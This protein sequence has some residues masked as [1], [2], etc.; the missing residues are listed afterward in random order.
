MY[1]KKLYT[2]F[3]LTP[4]FRVTIKFGQSGTNY[5]LFRVV[6]AQLKVVFQ[7]NMAMIN[8]SSNL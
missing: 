4:N 6:Q 3:S 1:D 5:P 2:P 7:N 8:F